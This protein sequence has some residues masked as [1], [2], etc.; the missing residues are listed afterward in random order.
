MKKIIFSLLLCAVSANAL[1][2]IDTI[3]TN[4][5]VIPCEIREVDANSVKFVYQGETVMN[6]LYKNA[7]QKIVYR[8]GRIQSFAEMSSFKKVNSVKDF[9]NVSISTAESEILGLYKVGEVSSK[10][11]GT[12][13]FAN[14]E[15]VKAR[16]YRK[17]K[18]VA[19]MMGANVI[20]LTSHRT[21]GNIG[22]I[23]AEASLTG[24]AYSNVLPSYESFRKQ[25]VGKDMQQTT[26]VSMGVSSSDYQE[27]IKVAPFVI[28]SIEEHG[29]LIIVNGQYQV[30]YYDDNGFNL[31]QKTK[32]MWLNIRVEF[33]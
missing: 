9:E 6:S 10:A 27:Q 25:V 24:I 2:Q 33:L 17:L 19:A 11:K 20:Y 21:Q 13:E 7:I 12:T 29:G 18:I 14:Q 32:N 1:A 31:Y 4:N 16:A 5:Q 22:D 26:V 15:R 23:S 3:Y 8:S 28:S 30:A